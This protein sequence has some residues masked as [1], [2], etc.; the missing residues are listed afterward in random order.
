MISEI[1]T[2]WHE[3]LALDFLPQKQQMITRLKQN[4]AQ[5]QA[6]IKN[7]QIR[8]EPREHSWWVTWYTSNFNHSG[9]MVLAFT[10]T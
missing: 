9:I 5:A 1:M 2:P 10:K 8:I 7:M 3:S 4:L 6:R